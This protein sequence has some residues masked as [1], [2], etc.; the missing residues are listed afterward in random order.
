MVV[1]VLTLGAAVLLIGLFNGVLVSSVIQHAL[2][3]L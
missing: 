3:E 1:P 2:P